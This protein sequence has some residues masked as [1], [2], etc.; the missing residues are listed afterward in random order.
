MEMES[1]AYFSPETR[2][3]R[4]ACWPALPLLRPARWESSSSCGHLPC[5]LRH[6]LSHHQKLPDKTM[7]PVWKVG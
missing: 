4:P 6:H 5:H 3:A 2:P 7:W 1:A